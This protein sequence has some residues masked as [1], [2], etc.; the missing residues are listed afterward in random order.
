MTG[1]SILV[2]RHKIIFALVTF[3]LTRWIIRFSETRYNI[4]HECLGW[5]PTSDNPLCKKLSS[6]LC[7]RAAGLRATWYRGVARGGSRGARLPPEPPQNLEDQLTLIKPRGADYTA[8][9]TAGPP[10]DSKSYL[11]LC[12]SSTTYVWQWFACHL[13]PLVKERNNNLKIRS[14]VFSK[15]QWLVKTGSSF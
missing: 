1:V 11:H 8:Y 6:V 4:Q 7:N 9:T 14:S 12:G 3:Y 10:P 13:F 15:K 5:S 2:W